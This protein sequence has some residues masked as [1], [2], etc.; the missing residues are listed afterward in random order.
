MHQSKVMGVTDVYRS[1]RQR[2]V[3]DLRRVGRVL[4]PGTIDRPPAKVRFPP[5]ADIPRV[6]FRA[7]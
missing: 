5:L 2:L 3:R 7:V 1:R 6:C 4:A